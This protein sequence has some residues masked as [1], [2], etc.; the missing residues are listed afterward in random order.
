MLTGSILPW[1][2]AQDSKFDLFSKG[3]SG[4]DLRFLKS[5][6]EKDRFLNG[7]FL[8]L[9]SD[10]FDFWKGDGK[11]CLQLIREICD[12]NPERRLSLAQIRSNEWVSQ[13]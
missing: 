3:K 10:W 2:S 9:A 11:E 1:I 5:F 8:L 4:K 12:R 13:L 7:D 6:W